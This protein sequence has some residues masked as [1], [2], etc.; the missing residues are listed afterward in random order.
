MASF[1]GSLIAAGETRTGP[2]GANPS[3]PVRRKY[4]I[5][6]RSRCRISRRTF[7]EA[8]L[9]V[10]EL[11]LPGANIVGTCEAKHVVHCITLWDVLASL[12][13]NNSHF[14]FII[15]GSVLRNGWNTNGFR[16][17][18][19][20]RIARLDEENRR[21]WNWHLDLNGMVSIIKPHAEDYRDRFGWNGRK[22]LAV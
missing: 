22:E 9:T 4:T 1:W 6:F 3:K 17:W 13:N 16:V 8:P 7:G 20:D 5:S 18:T 19:T 11:Q 2:M 10:R 21:F 12:R 15:A 14:C